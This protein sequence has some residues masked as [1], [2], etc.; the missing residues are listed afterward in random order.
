MN[1]YSRALVGLSHSRPS[2]LICT[3]LSSTLPSCLL[4]LQFLSQ[5]I[6]WT[7]GPLLSHWLDCQLIFLIL[8]P[9]Q[10]HGMYKMQQE[11]KPYPFPFGILVTVKL[12]ICQLGGGGGSM[13]CWFP[14]SFSFSFLFSV[15]C[16]SHSNQRSFFK[17][18]LNYFHSSY[19]KLAFPFH[20]IPT[21][22]L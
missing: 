18:F 22:T 3:K 15:F 9:C 21:P 10:Q 20:S 16:L 4:R 6:H 7:S 17:C 11:E 14:V 1:E 12:P 5:L 13:I 19:S 2:L 8:Y